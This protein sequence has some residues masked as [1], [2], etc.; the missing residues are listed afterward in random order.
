MRNAFY[1]LVV[2]AAL[3][4]FCSVAFAWS[5]PGHELIAAEAFRDLSPA[6]QAKATE[7]LKS[8]PDYAKWT[9]SYQPGGLDLPTF[10]FMRAST[11]PDEI[12]RGGGADTKYD[13]PHWHYVDWPRRS[14]DFP[15]GQEPNPTH[16]VL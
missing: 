8:H 14:P 16:N 11:W 9:N 13:H 15:L 3:F 12:R 6:L 4:D 7:I 2:T 10:I 1:C 5:G